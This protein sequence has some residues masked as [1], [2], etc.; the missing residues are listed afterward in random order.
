MT[1]FPDNVVL[2]YGGVVAVPPPLRK[3]TAQGSFC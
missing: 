3:I 1:S 2:H